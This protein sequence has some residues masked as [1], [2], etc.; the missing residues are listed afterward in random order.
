MRRSMSSLERLHPLA[1][2]RVAVGLHHHLEERQRAPLGQ[3][4]EDGV[5][6]QLATI[7]VVPC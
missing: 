1:L 7:R 5:R 3:R 2:V 6:E 4:S